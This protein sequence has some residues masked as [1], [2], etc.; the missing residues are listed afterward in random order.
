MTDIDL[1]AIGKT[2]AD[3][4][5][6]NQLLTPHG[7]NIARI[8]RRG[9]RAFRVGK[10]GE[11]GSTTCTCWLGLASLKEWFETPTPKIKE[12][13]DMQTRVKVISNG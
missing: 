6:L 8:P 7:V 11:A 1:E 9:W 10:P 4:S 5:A 12:F 13:L 3:L 2:S